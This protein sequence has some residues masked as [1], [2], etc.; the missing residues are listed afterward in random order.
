MA[1][2]GHVITAIVTPFTDD[3]EVD[4]DTFTRLC[5]H[6]VGHG[7]D[8]LVVAGTTG[9]S[10]TLSDDEKLALFRAAI[11]A[12]GDR[13]NVIA[14]TSTYDTAHSVRLT[15]AA[16]ELGVDGILAVTPYYSKPDQRGITRHFTAM[17]DAS[18]VPL[19]LYNIPGRTA[20]LVEVAT[21]VELAGHERIVA[22]KDAV[23]DLGFSTRQ[24]ASADLAVYSGADI[25]NLPLAAVGAVG[26]VSVA[27]HLV[28]DEIS[29]MLA[30][31][32]SGDLQGALAIH[33]SL[34]P[35]YDACFAEPSPQP[36]KG[37][38]GVL[39]DGVGVPR[40]PLVEAEPETVD[41]LV[42]AV[43]AVKG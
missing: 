32:R 28:G 38:L 24:H 10:P 1:P 7:S 8:G 16:C 35:V 30:L 14:G 41:A 22:V 11:D 25:Y 4:Y 23:E 37:A 15:E 13:A 19:M 2:F 26:V 34:I 29:A 17:A 40:L 18:S 5:S 20:R 31:V 9:E 12:V 6:L 39:W 33:E 21:L 36:L 42:A 27:S 43:R 3:G